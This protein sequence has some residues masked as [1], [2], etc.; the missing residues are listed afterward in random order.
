MKDKISRTQFNN[1]LKTIRRKQPVISTFGDLEED[2]G[3][4]TRETQQANNE[5]IKTTPA[6]WRINKFSQKS[7]R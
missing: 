6:K 3:N 2:V 1:K 5:C 7:N 4:I